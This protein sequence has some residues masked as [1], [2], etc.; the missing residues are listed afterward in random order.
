MREYII[1]PFIPLDVE[2]N[3]LSS[4]K[5]I[6]SLWSLRNRFFP[7]AKKY[8]LHFLFPRPYLGF[9]GVE[10]FHPTF[11]PSVI[12]RQLR[13]WFDNCAF[14]FRNRA[15]KLQTWLVE[16]LVRDKSIYFVMNVLTV[17]E[18]K[19]VYDQTVLNITKL[20]EITSI[21]WRYEYSNENQAS[22]IFLHWGAYI[23]DE[24]NIF[25]YVFQVSVLLAIHFIFLSPV[26][27]VELCCS[28]CLLPPNETCWMSQILQ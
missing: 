18:F 28:I 11:E 9:F 5:N 26:W 4:L 24:L 16:M 6:S 15:K 7:S 2:Y 1:I 3:I 12:F 14:S 17:I 22:S 23:Y 25:H 8:F 27:W 20:I 13:V 19:Y 10:N 21:V